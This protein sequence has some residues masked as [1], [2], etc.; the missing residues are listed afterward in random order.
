[1]I[2]F[3]SAK[4]SADKPA[5]I[6]EGRLP[7]TLYLKIYLYVEVKDGEP[8]WSV[9]DGK[10]SQAWTLVTKGANAAGL[11]ANLKASSDKPW[12]IPMPHTVQLTIEVEEFGFNAMVKGEI[13]FQDDPTAYQLK[14]ISGDAKYLKLLAPAWE[15]SDTQAK[16]KGCSGIS[17]K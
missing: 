3:S 15:F 1:M 17:D 13:T 5:E 2:V 12:N 8:A 4:Y 16:V 10:S 7:G 9:Q 6:S 11:A 14:P